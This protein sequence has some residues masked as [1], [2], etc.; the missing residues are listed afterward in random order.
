MKTVAEIRDLLW[1]GTA[2]DLQRRLRRGFRYWRRRPEYIVHTREYLRQTCG[3]R[4]RELLSRFDDPLARRDFF[5]RNKGI[6]GI[7]YKEA[8]HFLRNV[9]CQGYA[10]LDK[11]IMASLKEYGVVRVATPP[12]NRAQYH[13]IERKVLAFAAR[14]GIGLDELDLLLWSRKTGKILK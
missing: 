13:R 4:L 14:L 11:H 12:K 8:S 9:G 10:I 7:G 5:A 3:L 2:A 1:E 6:K